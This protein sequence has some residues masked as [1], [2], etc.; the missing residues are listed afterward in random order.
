MPVPIKPDLKATQAKLD[1]ALKD[2]Q[3]YPWYLGSYIGIP[4][5]GHDALADG[6]IV[7]ALDGDHQA[8][9]V[10]KGL[11]GGAP[12]RVVRMAGRPMAGG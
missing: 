7:T 10:V 12:V 2:P 3:K 8:E 11:A 5:G 9:A 6:V 4:P 1:S